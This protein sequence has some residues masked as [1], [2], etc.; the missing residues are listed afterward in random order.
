MSG[1]REKEYEGII[2][3]TLEALVVRAQDPL[4]VIDVTV[5]EM[6]EGGSS[7]AAGLNA[8]VVGLVEAGV[9]LHSLCAAVA[10]ALLPDGSAA[11][12]PDSEEE[13]GAEAVVTVAVRASDNAIL[14][15]TCDGA[16]S[17]VRLL[18][19]VQAATDASKTI[20]TLVRMALEQ[21]LETEQRCW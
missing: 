3:K 19:A 1:P 6:L 16:V 2:R 14:A 21:R 18:G 5:Q 9:A 8:A 15:C 17:E 11:L 12:D 7:L 13:A 10:V 4:C 20:F